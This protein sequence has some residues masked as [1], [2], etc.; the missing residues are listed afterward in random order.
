MPI[1]IGIETCSPKIG[2]AASSLR[3]AS[4]MSARAVASEATTA[5]VIRCCSSSPVSSSPSARCA[6]ARRVE[7]SP[8]SASRVTSSNSPAR[9]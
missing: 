8:S 1:R 5:R 4:A 7:I 2:S 6:N 9:P 3:R